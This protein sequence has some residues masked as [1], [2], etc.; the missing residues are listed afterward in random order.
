MKRA[1][2]QEADRRRPW[3]P[4]V[5]EL[6]FRNISFICIWQH[7]L[8]FRW[9]ANEWWSFALA[10]C[11]VWP[12]SF[13]Q[14]VNLSPSL[15]L[16]NV[17]VEENPQTKKASASEGVTRHFLLPWACVWCYLMCCTHSTTATIWISNL[18]AAPMVP[19][20]WLSLGRCDWLCHRRCSSF[21]EKNMENSCKTNICFS[22]EAAI[23]LFANI[24]ALLDCR[25]KVIW[26]FSLVRRHHHP[27]PV[28][29]NYVWTIIWWVLRS[30]S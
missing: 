29:S 6:Q 7:V 3:L 16:C 2:K 1:S 14:I 9:L 27:K 22:F 12:I 25:F 30:A 28:A 23:I 24:F 17:F 18:F 8:S 20:R 11:H 15:S 19:A 21:P 13:K 26:I 4:L 10:M 5:F